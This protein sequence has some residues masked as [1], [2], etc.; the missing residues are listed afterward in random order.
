MFYLVF[1]DLEGIEQFVKF[2][3]LLQFLS[4]VHCFD[5]LKTK[6]LKHCELKNE[7]WWVYYE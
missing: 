1:L 7:G 6:R 5:I 2:D 4:F 3:D